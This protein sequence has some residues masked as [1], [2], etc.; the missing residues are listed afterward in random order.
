MRRP[1]P[2]AAAAISSVG[3]ATERRDRRCSSQ[4]YAAAMAGSRSRPYSSAGHRKLTAASG[5]TGKP[6]GLRPDLPASFWEAALGWK[7]RPVP[8]G[9]AP[10]DQQIEHRDDQQREARG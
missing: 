9:E 8:A 6:P 4:T 7:R 10:L 1:G 5:G 3:N 2:I